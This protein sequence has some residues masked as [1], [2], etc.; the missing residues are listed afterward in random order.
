MNTPFDSLFCVRF[1]IL[2]DSI[3]V[4]APFRLCRKLTLALR[5]LRDLLHE[6][7]AAASL[8][9]IAIPFFQLL[10]SASLRA[11]HLHRLRLR[12]PSHGQTTRPRRPPLLPHSRRFLPRPRLAHVSLLA[13]AVRPLFAAM[14]NSF[15]SRGNAVGGAADS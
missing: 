15:H 10:P 5:C 9:L 2:C 4:A 7:A 8:S 12:L 14:L 11:A 3:P 13:L 6:F 1:A